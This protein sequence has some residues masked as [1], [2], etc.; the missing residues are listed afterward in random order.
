MNGYAIQQNTA[1]Q[2]LLFLL[3]SSADHISPLTGATATAV[4]S[5]AGGAFGS[6]A[7][8][9]SEVGDGWYKVAPNATDSDTLG[10]LALHAT[11]TGADP[12]DMLYMI[13]AY[14]PLD[15]TNLGL[16]ALPTDAPGAASG[17]PQLDGSGHLLAYSVSQP[18]TVGTN[19]DKAGYSL[20][21]APPTAAQIAAAVMGD[22][23]D[24]VGADVVAILQIL[25][26]LTDSSD[27]A[28]L[29]AHAL[30]M[31]P[32]GGGGSV[33]VAGYA[34]GQ[35]PASYILATPANKLATDATGAAA[36]NVTQWLGKECEPTAVDGVPIVDVHYGE[37]IADTA[38]AQGGSITTAVLAASESLSIDLTNQYIAFLT[39]ACANQARMITAS[40]AVGT[41]VTVTVDHA[42]DGGAMPMSGDLY[43][44]GGYGLV[45]LRLDQ[46][47]GAAR[48]VDGLADTDLTL[49][50]ACHGA[51]AS[52]AGPEDASSGTSLVVKTPG[53]TT[54]RT[55][56][57]TT[58]A[59]NPFGTNFPVSRQ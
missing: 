27:R 43:R 11:A 29:T 22:V 24:T 38:E 57:I 10:P 50:D 35:D 30:A 3:I 5:K 52:A 46:R 47:L 26:G 7:G 42:W 49:N 15:A 14:D 23:T 51:I 1:N 59:T 45:T 39:G 19:D 6:P 36:A 13:V 20:A 56:T 53:G 9:V 41:Q 31:A 4:I 48:A 21:T 18:V 28:Q 55:F 34:A 17:L 54:F 12:C 32:T 2:P 16:S 40:S 8:A 25:D 58:S 44:L 37:G 33:T